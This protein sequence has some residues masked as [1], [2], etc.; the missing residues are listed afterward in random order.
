MRFPIHVPRFFNIPLAATMPLAEAWMT[1]LVTPAPSPEAKS[2]G[3]L[4]IR[5]R[6]RESFRL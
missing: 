6:S 4:V 1:P 2:P 3:T 5:S